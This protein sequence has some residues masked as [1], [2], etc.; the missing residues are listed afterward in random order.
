MAQR[1]ETEQIRRGGAGS[2]MG[3][4]ETVA[5]AAGAAGTLSRRRFALLQ[6]GYA[7]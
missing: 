2:G 3:G 5:S 7:D 6:L 4:P 1:I